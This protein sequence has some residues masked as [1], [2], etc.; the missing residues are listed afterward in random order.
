M[1]D[2]E[3]M[4]NSGFV[5]AKKPLMFKNVERWDREDSKEYKEREKKIFE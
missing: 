2:Q 3:D 1:L 5:K 4:E